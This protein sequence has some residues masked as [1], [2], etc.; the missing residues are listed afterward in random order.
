V[1][2]QGDPEESF[3]Y[4]KHTPVSRGKGVYGGRRRCKYRKTQ[5]VGRGRKKSAGV[6]S[7]QIQT[8]FVVGEVRIGSLVNWQKIKGR[9]RYREKGKNQVFRATIT[10]SSK[11]KELQEGEI[12][13]VA[14]GA[15]KQ[16]GGCGWATQRPL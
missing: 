5:D 3:W 16:K 15:L 8:S 6:S 4:F 9:E 12:N 7:L 11:R 10:L 14:A 2:E 13:G 1:S